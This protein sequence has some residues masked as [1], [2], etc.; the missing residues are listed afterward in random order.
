MLPGLA[1]T[2]CKL[3]FFLP[4]S[5]FKFFLLLVNDIKTKLILLQKTITNPNAD[6]KKRGNSFTYIVYVLHKNITM[7]NVPE[8]MLNIKSQY[9]ISI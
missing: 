2:R 9:E 3:C 5:S 6:F 7:I 1:D 4:S 8:Q